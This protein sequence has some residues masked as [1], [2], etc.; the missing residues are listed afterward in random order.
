MGVDTYDIICYVLEILSSLILSFE[1]FVV[2][3]I[4]SLAWAVSCYDETNRPSP[5][6]Q[7]GH[8]EP[9][10]KVNHEC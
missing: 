2:A 3:E 8:S 10:R 1:S 5:L 4:S 9:D 6:A 7:T